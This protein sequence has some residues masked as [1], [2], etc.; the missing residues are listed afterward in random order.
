MG[1]GGILGD[2]TC[3]AVVGS[4]GVERQWKRHRKGCKAVN[5][6]AGLQAVVQ[7]FDIWGNSLHGPSFHCFSL[8][9]TPHRILIPYPST[10]TNLSPTGKFQKKHHTHPSII[11]T[12]ASC[13]VNV[14]DKYTVR[15]I[16]PWGTIRLLQRNTSNTLKMTVLCTKTT[17]PY[18]R[19]SK[20]TE[21]PTL[22]GSAPLFQPTAPTLPPNWELKG[23]CRPGLHNAPDFL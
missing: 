10:E 11:H 19:F 16:L 7:G 12:F 3:G 9:Y 2:A 20:V 8:I 13:S 5:E 6:A 22:E 21:N 23:N 14:F 1:L 18:V 15:I 17:M 4:N